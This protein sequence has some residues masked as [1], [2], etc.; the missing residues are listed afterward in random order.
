[1]G[2]KGAKTK[3][4]RYHMSQ[5]W[6]VAAKVDAVL[7]VEYG[8]KPMWTGRATASQAISINKQDLYGG[9][10]KEGGVQGVMTVL[11]GDSDQLLPDA[12]AQ[13]LGR[14]SGSDCPGARGVTSLFFTGS[15]RMSGIP[16][17]NNIRAP[18][19]YWAANSPYLKQLAIEVERIPKQLD[20][21]TARIPRTTFSISASAIEWRYLVVEKDDPAV[22]TS[23]SYDDS[24]WPLGKGPFADAPWSR[25][26]DYGF[27]TV[28]A[29]T[30]P[31]AHK[32][33]VRRTVIFDEVPAT[34]RFDA[35]VD[36]RC[37]VYAN[38]S[39][40]GTVGSTYGGS[41]SI[42]LDR[43]KFVVGAN[44]IVVLAW[45]DETVPD[46]DNNHFWMD[47]RVDG[48]AAS[49]VVD[50]N[51]AHIIYECLTDT[52]WGLGE[53]P[54]N[55]DV[56][57]FIDA[58]RVLFA[59]NFGLSLVWDAASAIEDFVNL[60]LAHINGVIFTDPATG[61]LTLRL[62][63]DDYDIST[64]REINPDNA[65]LTRFSR[66]AWGDTINEVQVSWTDPAD[67]DAS[68]VILQDSGNIAQQGFINSS[69]SDYPGV[70]TLALAGN[71]AER[72]LRAAS[73]P[74]CTGE[75]EVNRSFY[76][77]TPM[78]VVK[79][80]WPEY[81][82][83][84]VYARATSVTYGDLSSGLS[85]TLAEDVFA[86]PKAEYTAINPGEW[87][88]PNPGE[89]GV[90][91]AYIIPSPYYGLASTLGQ[92]T[93]QIDGTT[94]FA[95]FL[96]AMDVGGA[97]TYDL[98]AETT[99]TNGQTEYQL[100]DDDRP[101]MTKT[102][103]AA[104]L[105]GA[106]ESVVSGLP[107]APNDIVILG[108]PSLGA[109][110]Q[111][112]ALVASV[113]EVAGTATLW[114]GVIDTTPKPW[115]AGTEVWIGALEDM[116]ADPTART[117][118][119]T[120]KYK[121]L[122]SWSAQPLESTPVVSGAVPA[123]AS[124]PYPPANVKIN[125]VDAFSVTA[126]SGAFSVTWAHRNKETQ[127]EQILKQSDASVPPEANVRYGLEVLNAV[128]AVLVSRGDIA[129]PSATI[130]LNYSGTITI[131]LRAIDD[132]GASFQRQVRSLTYTAGAATGS[133]ITAPTYDPAGAITI[134]DGGDLDA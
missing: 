30:V 86:Y 98:Y 18:G 57:S 44:T 33:W 62:V 12:L 76:D 17:V 55:I 81:G 105:P 128:G 75:A 70:R 77:L 27:P 5:W 28:P 63:R 9:D 71:L 23:P 29:T 59:E 89:G 94:T 121:S 19:F 61:L 116:A 53:S 1:M 99:L 48:L 50:A 67:E 85:L 26:G 90:K 132:E 20:P 74:L 92:P 46:P 127:A 88:P 103:T 95:V 107:V 7:K 35:Y 65:V 87:T 72:D 130:D 83:D 56:Q 41:F 15:G 91:G 58:A 45:D 123:R 51:P 100:V 69:N 24:W 110:A 97:S 10:K 8:E 106:A 108:A 16:I 11:M 42:N 82:V 120:V 104:A 78:E 112:F 122:P 64:V 80:H 43:T 113:D 22:Y 37:Q 126:A 124:L 109:S 21:L 119:S 36:N 114:R 39:L 131:R 134:I 54:L 49:D 14:P 32:L 125:G 25:P 133:T 3:V 6:G 118:N 93:P 96:S 111:E 2:S 31:Q 38:G 40:V 68:K 115:P 79:L 34:I 129:G 102:V 66:K 73:A 47:W 60:I 117:V 84:A 4:S 52:S 101:F 13:R